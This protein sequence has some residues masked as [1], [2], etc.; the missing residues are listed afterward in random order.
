MGYFV[1]NRKFVSGSTSMVV[2]AGDSADR[3]ASPV[4]GSFRY[5]TEIGTLEFFN[6]TVFKPVGI[7]GEVDI[8]VDSFV[9]DGSTLTF[10]MS[11]EATDA[12]QVIV[13]VGSIYQ[14]PT[15]TYSITGISN[16]DITF[17]SAPP[18]G[19]PINIIHNLGSTIAS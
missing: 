9:G 8:V 12:E 11:V 17:T 18:V 10:T 1:K 4:F 14:Q 2:P 6:G 16:I 7:A 19:E 3:P 5:N 13:F 15:T